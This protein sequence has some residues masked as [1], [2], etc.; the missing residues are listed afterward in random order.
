MAGLYASKTFQ[1]PDL[2][3]V[4]YVD[5]RMCIYEA[6]AGWPDGELHPIWEAKFG[7][8]DPKEAGILTPEFW[9][10]LHAKGEFLRRLNRYIRVRY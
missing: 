6:L 7:R 8:P 1:G 2:E 9:A 3:A 10:P 4:D 5:K